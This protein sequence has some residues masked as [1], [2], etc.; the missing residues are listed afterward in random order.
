[1]FAEYFDSG[2]FAEGYWTVV[3]T[4]AP[5]NIELSLDGT[6]AGVGGRVT[7]HLQALPQARAGGGSV[8]RE[9]VERMRRYLRP[10]RIKVAGELSGAL[11][12]IRL[13]GLY[14]ATLRAELAG[15]TGR[16]LVEH[17]F[18]A[19]VVAAEDEEWMLWLT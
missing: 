8:R 10:T 14:Q 15:A 1:V 5:D 19:D 7:L 13:A 2:Y 3:G 12:R 4:P 11:G 17:R 16:I 6:L 9:D 18:T